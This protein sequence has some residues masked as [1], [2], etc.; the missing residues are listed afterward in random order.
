ML[1]NIE[2]DHLTE[3]DIGR[4]LDDVD[5]LKGWVRIEARPTRRVVVDF[6]MRLGDAGR[7]HEQKLG[8][9]PDRSLADIRRTA[10]QLSRA[11]APVAIAL[12]QS[13]RTASTRVAVRDGASVTVSELFDG[14][15]R[16]ALGDRKDA[17]E[18]VRRSMLKDV[19]PQIGRQLA[20]SITATEVSAVLER[21]VERGAPRQ[22]GCVLADL[23]QMFRWGLQ[24][25]VIDTDP[26]TSLHK[27][28]FGG[29]AQERSRTLSADEVAELAIRM[30]A[31]RLAPHVRQAVWLLLA[32]G[33]RVGELV[34]A[35]WNNI[36]LSRRIWTIPAEFSHNGREHILP[37]SAFAIR[38]LEPGIRSK[39]SD[40]WVFPGRTPSE[41]LSA[42]ALG[43]Q[44]RDRQRGTQIRGRSSATQTLLLSGGAWTPLDLRRTTAALMLATGTDP[45][46]IATCLSQSQRPVSTADNTAVT[47]FDQWVQVFEVLGNRLQA[48]ENLARADERQA[49]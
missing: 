29:A 43:K 11:P 5:G 14:W 48:F 12:K 39:R 19:M 42:K 44:I 45:A 40:Q 34:Q 27:S 1:S 36:D 10:D 46:L 25:G 18:S 9:W 32:T 38:L 13:P 16:E 2:L 8:T 7:Q 22:A 24:A 47:A 21:I 17:G 33:V 41:A 23:R 6:T 37:L 31:G 26:T 3:S 35:R 28:D 20:S 30:D 4:C 49:A 15:H